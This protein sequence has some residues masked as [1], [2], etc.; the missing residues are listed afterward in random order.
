L[1][2]P[3]V[4]FVPDSNAARTSKHETGEGKAVE[5]AQILR[6]STCNFGL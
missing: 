1:P 3:E 5:A 4:E 6:L 2:E